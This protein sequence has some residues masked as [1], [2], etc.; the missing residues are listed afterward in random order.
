MHPEKDYQHRFLF[1]GQRQTKKE[2]NQ[3]STRNSDRAPK[4]HIF[5]K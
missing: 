5:K 2:N 1:Q 4:K 3:V